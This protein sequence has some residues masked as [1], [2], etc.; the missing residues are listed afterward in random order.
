MLG[1]SSREEYDSAAYA[2][3]AFLS[4]ASGD[5]IGEVREEWTRCRKNFTG[6]PFREIQAALERLGSAWLTENEG[7]RAE[8]G[9]RNS[10]S[11]R[12][13]SSYCG[14]FEG[15]SSFARLRPSD[16]IFDRVFRDYPG[17]G[18]DGA[19]ARAWRPPDS[20][21][22]PHAMRRPRALS[23]GSGAFPFQ[24]IG[25]VVAIRNLSP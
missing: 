3:K 21:I 8:E 14:P 13:E 25:R 18:G 5:E 2:L 19:L 10:H 1:W 6:K 20:R 16:A 24:T 12:G 11:G 7:R 15:F 23:S 4:E 17:R 9:R 22:H